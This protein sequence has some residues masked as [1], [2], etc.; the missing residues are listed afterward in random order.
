MLFWT[1][2]CG[3]RERVNWRSGTL[4]VPM[5]ALSNARFTGRGNRW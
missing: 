4:S 2:K 5:I 1:V 3:A